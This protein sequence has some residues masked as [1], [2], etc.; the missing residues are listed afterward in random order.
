MAFCSRNEAHFVCKKPVDRLALA[1]WRQEDKKTRKK[2][3]LTE[4]TY[5]SATVGKEMIVI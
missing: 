1:L 3:K 4:G 2:K 5:K